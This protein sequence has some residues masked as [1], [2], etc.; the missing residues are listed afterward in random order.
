M[1]SAFREFPSIP[2][3][4]AQYL[5]ADELMSAPSAL[6]TPK[7]PYLFG[8]TSMWYMFYRTP[9]K[10]M[11][12]AEELREMLEVYDRLT[13]HHGAGAYE[14]YLGEA[15]SVQ[16]R[17]DESD[18][19]SRTVRHF[20]LS[21][22]GE[23]RCK[24]HKRVLRCDRC[25]CLLLQCNPLGGRERHYCGNRRRSVCPQRYLQQSANRNL[26]LPLYGR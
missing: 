9:G 16:G 21:C 1:V 22:G 7:E 15:L 6:F 24:W 18:I 13:N 2:D 5:A 3:M 14:L 8:T 19:Y 10:M 12:T 4:K 11:E 25:G 20:P 17:F 26:Y 23:S